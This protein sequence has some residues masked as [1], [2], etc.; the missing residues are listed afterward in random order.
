[1][2]VLNLMSKPLNQ[3]DASELNPTNQGNLQLLMIGGSLIGI[4]FGLMIFVGMYWLDPSFHT[5]LT[6]KPF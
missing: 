5:Y 3:F 6:G 4:N 2:Q 1:M